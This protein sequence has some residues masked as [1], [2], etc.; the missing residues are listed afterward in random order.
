MNRVFVACI[1]KNIIFVWISSGNLQSYGQV[2]KSR[3]KLHEIE[4]YTNNNL[5][6]VS[7]LNTFRDGLSCHVLLYRVESDISTAFIRLDCNEMFEF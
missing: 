7:T 4:N 1:D 2:S 6:S 5:R 3:R